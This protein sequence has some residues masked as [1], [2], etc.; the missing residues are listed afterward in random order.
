[1]DTS[2][3]AI[4]GDIV[5]SR[6]VEDREQLQQ[7]LRRTLQAVNDAFSHEIISA[8]VLTTG[9]EFQGLLCKLDGLVRI[10]RTLRSG[11]HPQ[12]V[13]FGLGLGALD[14]QLQ[15]QA[16]GMDGPC[17]HRARDAIERAAG[18]GTPLEMDVGSQQPALEIYSLLYGELR[19]G[20]TLKQRQVVDLAAQGLEGV[21]IA[22]K[23]QISPSA[24]SQH[25]HAA[26]FPAFSKATGVWQAHVQAMFQA[27]HSAGQ[28]A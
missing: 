2:Y 11:L 18:R 19:R 21:E 1:M 13:R 20:W 5:A 25:L 23:L 4:I 17:F 10:L 27:Q 28:G 3:L 8:F 16:I 9:D 26:G 12:E 7:R 14:T 22:H 6:E 24:V 15:P